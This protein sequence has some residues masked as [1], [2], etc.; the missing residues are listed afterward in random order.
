MAVIGIFE[1]MCLREHTLGEEPKFR[2]RQGI[3]PRRSLRRRY[4]RAFFELIPK[5]IHN[6][7][8]QAPRGVGRHPGRPDGPLVVLPAVAREPDALMK[9]ARVSRSH[10]P[11]TQ[12]GCAQCRCRSPHA[13]HR[14]GVVAM[15]GRRKHFGWRWRSPQIDKG[16]GDR[17]TDRPAFC[18]IHWSGEHEL[19]AT[20][21]RNLFAS[22]RS[23]SSW[24][25]RGN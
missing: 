7:R 2:K 20:P 13:L 5:V 8:L 25:R 12:D 9:P 3:P 10:R 23:N 16:R 4:L 24:S 15:P 18:S 22:C 17:G 11:F 14:C 6:F 19:S 1:W 21:R